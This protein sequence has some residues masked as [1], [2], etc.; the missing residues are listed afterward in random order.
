MRTKE[1]VG[2]QTNADKFVG[3]TRAPDLCFQT[4]RVNFPLGVSRQQ[5]RG[6]YLTK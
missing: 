1:A 3:E 5:G 2:G 6:G 4:P